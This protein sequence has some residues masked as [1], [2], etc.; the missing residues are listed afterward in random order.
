MTT[1]FCTLA[2]AMLLAADPPAKSDTPR[3]P[4]PF[5]PSLPLLTEQEEEEL[6]QVIDR[7]IQAD[8]GKLRGD[9]AK[10]ALIAFQKLGPEAIP[11]LIRGMNRAAHIEASCPAVVIAKK[12]K[13]M[14]SAT[15]DRELLEFA[16]ENI[17][18]GVTQSVHM[19]VLKDLKVY[20]MIRKR[21]VSQQVASAPS[22]TIRP[23]ELQSTAPPKALRQMTVEELAQAAGSER[24]LRLK[25]VLMELAKRDGEAVAPALGSAATSYDKDIQQLSRDLLGRYLSRQDGPILKE[26]LKDERAEVRAAAAR[27]VGTKGLHF[28]KELIHLLA[29][30]SKEVRQSAHQALVKL[31]PGTDFG[32]DRNATE[33]ERAN[34]VQEWSDWLA[35]Q[36][37]DEG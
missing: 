32:P 27:S 8:I 15:K 4:N 5:A 13:T 36:K 23:A 11:A 10:R 12:L 35:K 1:T 31:N 16:R 20:C 2:L 19:G 37:R 9:E 24:G 33:S 29:D 6:D 26:K 21:T 17:G 3:K 7:F 34:A 28:E 14:F 22:D 18:A 25:E 30:E